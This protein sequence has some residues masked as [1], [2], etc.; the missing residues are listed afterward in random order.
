[1][2]ASKFILVALTLLAPLSLTAL[3]ADEPAK[4]AA[5]EGR[6]AKGE[7]GPKGGDRLANL[8]EQLSLTPAQVEQIKPILNSERDAMRALN[9]DTSLDREAKRPKMREI[10]EAH[11]AKIRA[12]L[13]PE[14][15]AKMD[16]MRPAG[17]KKQRNNS[18]VS[19]RAPRSRGAHQHGRQASRLAAVSFAEPA[20]AAERSAWFLDVI[21]S[22]GTVVAWSSN[23]SFA[24]LGIRWASFC[25]KRPWRTST[26]VKAIRSP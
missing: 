9:Q 22:V 4:P 2:K 8:T 26:R 14:Q 20:H 18:S 5:R 13:T 6:P 19:D 23:S 16:A 17:G 11:D 12:L 1:M 3:R 15:Q 25:R 21:I 7:K 10:R 24:K